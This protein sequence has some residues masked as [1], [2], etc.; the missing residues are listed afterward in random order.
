[1]TVRLSLSLTGMTNPYAWHCDHHYLIHRRYYDPATFAIS[2]NWFSE[3]PISHSNYHYLGHVN[4]F[5]WGNGSCYIMLSSLPYEIEIFV[6]PYIGLAIS[7][8]WDSRLLKKYAVAILL[9]RKNLG[10]KFC[11]KFQ[12]AP[13]KLHTAF[14][15]HAPQNMHFIDFD[16][17]VCF[18]ISLKCDV[19]SLS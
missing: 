8:V 2:C 18:T 11:V 6:M 12:R 4:L 14:W 15:T 16:V 13:L 3:P 9:C 1:M 19:I 10:S 7:Q 17:R 5:L